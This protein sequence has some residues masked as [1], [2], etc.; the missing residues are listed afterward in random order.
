LRYDEEFT[1]DAIYKYLLDEVKDLKIDEGDDPP[2]YYASFEDKKIPLEITRSESSFLYDGSIESCNSIFEPILR[3][4]DSLNLRYKD[5]FPDNIALLI[6]ITGPVIK[7]NKFKNSLS[8]LIDTLTSSKITTW[9]DWMSYDVEGNRI[10]LKYIVRPYGKRIIGLVNMSKDTVIT[11]IQ[12]QVNIIV[13]EILK[14][15]ESK[16][17][18]IN[19][20][21]W[22]AEKWL[23]ILNNYFLSEPIHFIEAFKSLKFYH[24]FSRV[25]LVNYDGMVYD[26]L[27]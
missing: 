6:Q 19:G 23:G 21:A 12:S 14:K 3:L 27:E 15:K 26:L 17:N 18:I 7:Y 24:S 20:R 25:F 1:K 13:V 22:K 10:S 16:T 9:D 8:G 5:R 4:C 11:N 2:D